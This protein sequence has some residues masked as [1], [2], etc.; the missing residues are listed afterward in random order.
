VAPDKLRTIR[1][2]GCLAFTAGAILFQAQRLAASCDV[3]VGTYRSSPEACILWCI[4]QHDPVAA[5]Q[6]CQ[7]S[8]H[9]GA[10]KVEEY[11]CNIEQEGSQYFCQTT[12]ECE[13][14][15]PER[16]QGGTR[17]GVGRR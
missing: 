8:C 2:F 6:T 7:E 10:K 4:D 16:A 12:V 3:V 17:T 5:G 9:S 1:R 14:I 15:P 11:S 13:P